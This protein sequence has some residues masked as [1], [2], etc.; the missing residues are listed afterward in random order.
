MHSQFIKSQ[1]FWEST[2]SQTKDAITEA[3]WNG[4]EGSTV[5]KYCLSLRKFL[6]FLE[7]KSHSAKLPFSS[8]IVA[9]YLTNLKLSNSSKGAIDSALSSLKWIH[10]F[11][12][13]INKTNN[14][15]MDEFLA[16]INNGVSRDMGKPTIQKK[17]LSGEMVVK[18]IKQSDLVNMV[19]LRNCLLIAFAYNLLLRHDE[20]SHVNLAH[21]SES[22]GGFK[23]LIPKSKTDKYR[24]GKH[25]FLAKNDNSYSPSY[26]LQKYIQMAGLKIGMNHFLFSPLKKTANS[27][28]AM[29]QMLS[30]S[31]FRDIVKTCIGKIGLDPKC[32]GTHSL[33]AG[34]ATDLAPHVSEHE[35]LVSGRWADARSIRSYVELTNTERFE[36]SKILQ[37]KMTSSDLH[38]VT[39]KPRSDHE[40]P[41]FRGDHEA[42]E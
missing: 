35:L 25:V 9:E 10:S 24:N 1:S 32:F 3:I 5:G 8:M 7:E 28:K 22:E 26:L 14:P 42:S 2:S 21:I 29:N 36:L 11:V 6:K 31:S 23:I 18:I 33:R 30:Y 17:P 20:F 16:K 39:T 38:E 19:E 4:R 13:G 12:P 34:G 15:M 37:N 41:E 27:W 40:T